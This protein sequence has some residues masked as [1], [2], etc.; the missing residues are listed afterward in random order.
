MKMKLEMVPV[1][2]LVD[3]YSLVS[4]MDSTQTIINGLTQSE[5]DRYGKAINKI[6]KNQTLNIKDLRVFDKIDAL[7]YDKHGMCLKDSQVTKARIKACKKHRIQFIDRNGLIDH[8][9]QMT[10]IQID[11][12]FNQELD[13]RLKEKLGY[14]ILDRLGEKRFE[15]FIEVLAKFM[16]KENLDIEELRV[17]SEV[18]FLTCGELGFSIFPKHIQ[19]II[20]DS[21]V[22][23]KF[24]FKTLSK[25]TIH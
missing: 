15:E 18:E 11:K 20:D 22:K 23:Y 3:P 16:T 25:K 4:M 10:G 1:E 5:L 8:M 2:R 12:D 6:E 24:N 19:K 9:N 21:C 13:D 14:F 17:L 7:T